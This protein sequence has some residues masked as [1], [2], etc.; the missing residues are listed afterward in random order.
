[1]LE[2]QHPSYQQRKSVN[3]QRKL[4]LFIHLIIP[5]PT[6]PRKKKIKLQMLY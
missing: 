1:M 2:A 5:S 4:K 6:P 3:S